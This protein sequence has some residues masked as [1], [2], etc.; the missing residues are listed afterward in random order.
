MF[1]IAIVLY[2]YSEILMGVRRNYSINFFDS[3]NREEDE[4]NIAKFVRL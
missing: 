3:G 1:D 2:E 4:E